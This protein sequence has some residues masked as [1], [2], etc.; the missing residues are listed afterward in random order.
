MNNDK[1]RWISIK[2]E[3]P[4]DYTYVLGSYSRWNK[5][6]SFKDQYTSTYDVFIYRA[7]GESFPL[8]ITHWKPINFPPEE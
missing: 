8:K 3:K 5:Y 6:E 1:H 4:K 2:D 7:V